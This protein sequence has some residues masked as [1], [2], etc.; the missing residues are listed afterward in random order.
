MHNRTIAVAVALFVLIVAGMFTFAYLKKSELS[1][2]AVTPQEPQTEPLPGPY[3][4]IDRIEAK[5]FY[6]D[7]L[8]TLVGEIAM[9][10]PCDL[11][12]WD[13]IVAESFPEQA[14][15]DFNVI[16]TAEMCAEVITPQRFKVEF[17]ASENASIRARLVGR[18][19]ELNLIPP[20]EGET[21][22]D[23]EIFIKG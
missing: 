23:F 7:G 4:Y 19:V 10:T 21:P 16:N 12:E 2:E 9:P 14:T 8:H 20:G 17:T 3:D 6:I 11:L 1:E 5:H 22:D 13:T 18:E 15:M